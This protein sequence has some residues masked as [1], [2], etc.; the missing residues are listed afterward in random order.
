M[1][2]SYNWLKSYVPELPEAEKLADVFTYHLCEVESVEK[3]GEGKS[4]DRIFDINILPNRAHDLLSHQGIAQELAGLLGIKFNDPTELYKIPVS[5][6]TKLQIKSE[7]DA[8]RRYTGRI[9]RNITVQKSPEWV[10][11]HLESIG[12]RSIN[13]IVDATNIVMYDCGQ[14]CHAFDLRHLPNETVVVKNASDGE[15]LELLGSEKL[16]V[17]LKSSDMVIANDAGVTLGI[18]GVKGGLHSGV[19]NDTKDIVLEVANFDPVAV[20]KTARRLSVLTDSAKR[21]END[22]SPTH[23]D[24]AMRALSALILEMCP[25]AQFENIVNFEQKP[26]EKLREI[27]FETGKINN[28]LGTEITTDEIGQILQKYAFKYRESGGVFHMEIPALRLDLVS[29]NDV[30]EEIGRVIGYDK[31][32]PVIPSTNFNTKNSEKNEKIVSVR[33][34]LLEFGYSEVMTYAFCKKGKVEVAYGTGGEEFLRTNLTDGMKKSY[35]LNRLN[36]PILGLDEIKI[37]EIGNV[38]PEKDLEET[39]V[40]IADKKG[41]R[42]FLITEFAEKIADENFISQNLIAQKENDTTKFIAEFNAKYFVKNEHFLGWSQ[43]PFITR[44]IAV[45]VPDETDPKTLLE[46]FVEHGGELLARPPR[47]FD[48]FSKDGKTSFA[49]RLVFQAQNKTLTDAET[50]TIVDNINNTLIN[51]GFTT[52]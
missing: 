15:E 39:R 7:T 20:R 34:K 42:E 2:I 3:I 21:F 16:K 46:I 17:K 25:D 4:E 26:P 27:S 18:A 32:T 30:A 29:V 6:E 31:L 19:A 14:P 36:A 8:C 28:M 5:T 51:K 52:R 10:I 37:F 24:Y 1:K 48:K 38:F 49:F 33:K 43:F 47:L 45:W 41:V 44:D 13:N 40:A 22:L 9:V 11:R 12:Q 35:E 50:Y 23:C